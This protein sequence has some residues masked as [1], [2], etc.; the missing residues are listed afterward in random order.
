MP[1]PPEHD[2]GIL[3]KDRASILAQD[4]VI[5]LIKVKVIVISIIR[6][7]ILVI[8]ITAFHV[9]RSEAYKHGMST[10]RQ[11][12]KGQ[13]PVSITKKHYPRSKQVT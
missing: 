8:V 9:T 11:G 3:S 1:N 2:G 6:V 7:I 4:V 10:C 12:N 5:L 13:G